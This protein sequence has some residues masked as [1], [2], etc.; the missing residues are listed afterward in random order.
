MGHHYDLSNV[1][2]EC[3]GVQSTR[4]WT[5]DQ[6]SLLNDVDSKRASSN[7]N[8]KMVTAG[9]YLYF[10]DGSDLCYV[11]T[12]T[13]GTWSVTTVTGTSGTL[14]DIATDGVN[15]WATSGANVYKTTVGAASVSTLSTEDIDILNY[16][17]GRLMGAED[18]EIF[19]CSDFGA[20][21]FTSLFA[22][23]NTN[24]STQV[25]KM[26]DET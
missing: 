9:S 25:L 20:G 14:L 6:I 7:T 26:C 16:T 3:Y 8:L 21:T 12:P 5:D 22:H 18:N 15:V 10:I 11:T 13:A 1:F 2:I 4:F 17:K 24:K 23:A 19:Y